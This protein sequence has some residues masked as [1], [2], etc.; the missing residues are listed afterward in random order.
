MLDS[1]FGLLL[2]DFPCVRTELVYFW[3]SA[4]FSVEF[5]NFVQRVNAYIHN[6]VIRIHQLDSFLRFSFDLNFLQ[7]AK[8]S[9]SVVDMRHIIAY[10]KRIQLF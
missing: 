7:A 8:P 4:V 3:R 2:K 9:N 1:C 6:V 10:R 5:G